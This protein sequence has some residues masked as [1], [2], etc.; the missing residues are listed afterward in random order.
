MRGDLWVDIRNEYLKGMTISEIARKYNIDWRTANKYA[1]AS[2]IPSYTRSKKTTSKL[3]D[4]KPIINEF[5]EEAPYTAV[6]IHEMIEEQG[7]TGKYGLVKNYV[8]KKKKALNTKATVRFETMPGKQ[9]QVDW[10]HFG[11]FTDE[12]GN[13]RNLYCFLMILGYS[14]MRYIEFVTD[15][16]TETLINCH[17]NAFRYF[18]GYPE[19]IL[20]DNMKQVVIKRVLK[21]KDSTLN[22]LFK[23]FAGYYGFKP[24]LCR[25]YRGQTKGKVER[26]VRYVRENFF[27][28]LTFSNLSNLNDSAHMWCEKVNNRVHN[29]TQERPYERLKKEH[30]HNV[31]REY[32]LPTKNLRKVEKDCLISFEGNQYS[33]PPEYILKEVTVHKKNNLIKIYHNQTMVATHPIPHGSKN[34]IIDKKHYESISKKAISDEENTIFDAYQMEEVVTRNLSVFDDLYGGVV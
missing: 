20:Y 18:G 12:S 15:M 22:P 3:D 17:N 16:T 11:K 28:G 14:R 6:R 25:P 33:V 23:D 10:G 24:I 21:Q 19:E 1:K 7:Y 30:L 5:L 34:K 2:S 26:T 27:M 31:K 32:L 4:F 9:G 29:T 8:K 13:E